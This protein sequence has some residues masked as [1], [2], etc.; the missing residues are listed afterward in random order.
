M[1]VFMNR[2]LPL[3]I[4][5]ITLT[6]APPCTAGVWVED[7]FSPHRGATELIIKTIDEARHSIHVAAYGFTS[8]PIA[9]ALVEAHER[10]VDVAVVL[11]KRANRRHGVARLLAMHG[12]PVRLNGHY[13]ILHDKFMIVDRRKLELGSFNYTRSAESRNAENVLV[14]AGQAKLIRDYGREWHRL[15]DEAEPEFVLGAVQKTP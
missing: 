6:I 7:A 13:A 15:W 4:A 8:R 11:D 14:I 10:G 5:I 2:L 9:E 1:V 3:L 12:I